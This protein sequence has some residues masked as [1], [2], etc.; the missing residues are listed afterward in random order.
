MFKWTCFLEPLLHSR[1]K[2][3]PADLDRRKSDK[4]NTANMCSVPI[5]PTA[6]TRTVPDH[7]D[8]KKYLHAA[9]LYDEQMEKIL[10]SGL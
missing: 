3:N 1:E 5:K 10:K 2:T 4:K 6:H 7:R 8:K 9:I